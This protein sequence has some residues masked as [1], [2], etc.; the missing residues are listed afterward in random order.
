[1]GL[2]TFWAIFFTNSSGHPESKTTNLCTHKQVKLPQ[3]RPLTLTLLYIYSVD[4]S[5]NAITRH[6]H[7]CLTF[8]EYVHRT[9]S[10][11]RTLRRIIIKSTKI[12]FAHR[13]TLLHQIHT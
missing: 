2:A 9:C 1:M 11:E 12:Y 13:W 4:A 6:L 7:I 8:M 3:D 5:A 10:V